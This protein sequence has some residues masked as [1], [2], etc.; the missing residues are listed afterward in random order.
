MEERL[1]GPSLG[2][3]E[4]HDSWLVRVTRLVALSQ[5]YHSTVGDALH[6][7]QRLH[8]SLSNDLNGPHVACAKDLPVWQA[9][10][11][12]CSM[13]SSQAYGFMCWWVCTFFYFR[14]LW[15]AFRAVV[16][17]TLWSLIR[18][19]FHVDSATDLLYPQ[20]HIL[21]GSFVCACVCM[22][23]VSFQLL[24]TGMN[25]MSFGCY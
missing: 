10:I 7:A 24:H 11:I 3:A 9:W 25:T 21:F 19:L 18:Y 13:I 4:G 8:S 23:I 17:S 2:G 6:A 12:F 20:Q 16:G 1:R 15:S 22:W 14:L 5:K